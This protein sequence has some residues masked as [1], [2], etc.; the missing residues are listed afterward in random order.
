VAFLDRKRYREAASG[1]GGGGGI[2]DGGMFRGSG[3]V[4][5]AFSVRPRQMLHLLKLKSEGSYRVTSCGPVT[6]GNLIRQIPTIV[7]RAMQKA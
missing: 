6:A 5:W 7:P 1:G 3:V 4:W 2:S